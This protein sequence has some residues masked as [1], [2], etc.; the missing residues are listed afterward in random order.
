MTAPADDADV[1]EESARRRTRILWIALAVVVAGSFAVLGG[2]GFRIDDEKPP[3]PLR[4][5]T[6]EGDEITDRAEIQRGQAVWQAMG[7]HQIGSIW[8]H[9][10]YVAP[11]WTADWLHREAT[12][13]LDRW[14]ADEG[15]ADFDALGTEQRAALGARLVEVI[16][17][18]T[19][20]ADTGVVTLD[21]VRAEAYESNVA[22]LS[23]VFR[24]GNDAYAIPSDAI[25]DPARRE[26]LGAFVFWTSWAASTERPG[27]D[28]T[29]T[30]NWPHE[31]LVENTPPADNIFWSIISI[32]LL[33]G[34][35]A[36]MVWYFASRPEDEPD[37]SEV[38]ENDPLLGYR[39]TP[40]QRATLKYF[41]VVMALLVLQI[42]VGVLAAHYG[43]EG[44]GFYGIPIDEILPYS[45]VRTWHTQLGVLWIATAFLATGLYLAPGVGGREPRH[46]RLGVNVLFGALLV[47][48]TGSLVGQW[49]SIKERLDGDSWFWFGHQGQEYLDIGR[50]WQIG[51][52]IGLILWLVLMVRGMSPALRRPRS[53]AIRGDGEW[54][55]A[56]PA[57]MAG[58]RQR[59]LVAMLLISCVA[60][61][62]FYGA[63]FGIGR[64][65]HLS[66]AEY[67]RWWVVHLW[68][69]GFF[70]VFATVVIAFLFTRL[71]LIRQ[72]IATAAVLL[73]TV[74]FLFGGILGTFH[75][76]YFTGTPAG[77]LALG[78]TFSALECVPLILIGFEAW[79]HLR[80]ARI[81]GWVSAYRWAIYFVVAVAF[82]NMLGA[83][84]FGFL[85]NPPIALFYVQGLNLTPL[86]GHTALFG[87][88]GMLGI[89]LMMLCV[90]GLMPGREWHE[91]SIK[92]GFWG[93]NL[94]LA[95]M[96]FLSLLPLGL[97][98]AWAS[99]DTGL[100]HARSSEFL[101]EPW[102][103]VFRWMR[104]PGDTVF[105]IGA[106]AIG[107]FMFGLLT[108]RSVKRDEPP[109]VEPGD[110][111]P[112]REEVTVS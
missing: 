77:V 3:I 8:G 37:P 30:Q 102:L 15:V 60:I 97:A 6:S 57:A 111:R 31:P 52:F 20:D 95:G 46:Q 85:I 27:S 29:Y 90:R 59:S 100:W 93:L 13:V 35:I 65:T 36:G 89:G 4:V 22:H 17:T 64:S 83:G 79:R 98:Q 107:W 16:R 84:L 92:V 12:F 9:G 87:V 78:A 103:Q 55:D 106:L 43:V 88:Y 44:S 75:H 7:G 34:G 104:I 61:A 101:D 11:D 63:A 91:R 50:V 23:D 109:V 40:S 67:W 21:P 38:P 72:S 45:V 49:L 58:T 94:G 1:V 80:L 70:E 53:Q 69:E 47:V 5:V 48:V 24:D 42:L 68:V 62:G 73:S 33:L 26:A 28:V 66:L 105:A 41:F 2:M 32:V 112:V 18:N 10:A 39:A 110:V 86:H 96:A 25:T 81:R 74:V 14:A 82:W 54:R 71:R 108:G 56:G 51:L 19:Y 76:L 99:I